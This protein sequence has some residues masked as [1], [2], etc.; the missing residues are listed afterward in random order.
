[1]PRTASRPLP[2]KRVSRRSATV[3]GLAASAAGLGYLAIFC[4]PAVLITAGFSWFVYVCLYTPLKRLTA[5]H[6][7][8]GAVS[9]AMPVLI[10]AAAVGA[11][12]RTTAIA[13]FGVAY[14]WQWPHTMAIGHLYREQYARA[15]IRV[16]SV[17][18]PSGR[19]AGLVAVLGAGALLV[20]SLLLPWLG[21]AGWGF[22]CFALILGLLY[23]AASV[24]FAHR[25]DEH[26][27][28]VLLRL[29]L[30]YLPLVLAGY[31]IAARL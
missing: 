16:A 5:W 17:V 31:L 12:T 10:G 15:G 29:S 20:V 11:T 30:A 19:L 2:A 27:S 14:L 3:W 23:L 9:G 1:M 13:L 21:P 24:R 6:T 22:A 18:D 26:A 28:R 8:V 25:R 4:S 7:A